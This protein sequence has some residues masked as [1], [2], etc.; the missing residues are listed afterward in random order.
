MHLYQQKIEFILFAAITTR[1]NVTYAVSRLRQQN[2]APIS[3]NH[4]AVDRIIQYLQ[5][6]RF[7]T[8]KFGTQMKKE[9][10]AFICA[11]DAVMGWDPKADGKGD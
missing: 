5:S 11:N 10:I 9:V 1:S 6:T 4:V 8:I 3:Q 7:L 2:T